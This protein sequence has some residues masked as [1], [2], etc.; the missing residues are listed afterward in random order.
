MNVT[1]IGLGI[2]GSRMAKNLL[3]GG[4]TLTVFNRSKESIQGLAAS[5]ASPAASWADAVRDADVVFTMLSSPEVLERVALGDGGFVAEMKTNAIWVD[6][7]TVNPSFS[8]KERDT[9]ARFGVRFVDAPVAGTKPHAETGDLTFLAGG[10][11]G[12][13]ETVR[14][15][16]KLMGSKIVHIGGTGKGAAFKMLVNSLLAQSMLAFSETVLLGETLGL[17]RDFLL[18]T[19]PNLPVSAPFIGA[20][21]E[22]IRQGNFAVQFPLEWMHKDLRLVA[23]TAR[24][25][26][27][28]LQSATL[29]EDLFGKATL[30]G[31]GREDFSAIYTFLSEQVEG[32]NRG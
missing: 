15:L 17:P 14:P 32:R 4:V 27:C 21:A 29:A 20:K 13:L 25:H 7:S 18:D 26:S 6:C 23:L 3:K 12:D 2:M 28:P 5:G 1:F 8:R 16:L 10:E 19:L 9:A 30:A 24:E 22:M 11:K 31:L